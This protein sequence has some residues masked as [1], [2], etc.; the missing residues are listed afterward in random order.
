[1]RYHDP[2]VEG[3]TDLDQ[4]LRTSDVVSLHVVLTSRSR[5]LLGARE[6]GLMRPSA[7]LV[8]TSR[9]GTVDEAA[10]AAAIDGG[11]LAGAAL[12]VFQREPLEPESP[13]LRCDPH[14]VTLTPHSIGH[15]LEVGPGG[16]RLAFE[17]VDRALRGKLP[18]NV[19]NPEVE[20]AWRERLARLDAAAAGR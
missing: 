13:L 9:G 19:V 10:L 3:S 2:V 5:G 6:L 8:N 17:T 18:E 4:L 11:H 16:A 14:R 7:V 20:P 1:V 15:S 12:D